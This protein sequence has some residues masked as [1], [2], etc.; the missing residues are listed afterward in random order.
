MR[1]IE[2]VQNGV[3]TLRKSKVSMISISA[4]QE[5]E[6]SWV[7]GILKTANVNLDLLMLFSG[8]IK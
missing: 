2:H 7:A 6:E 8:I 1:I 5:L 4:A 3:L